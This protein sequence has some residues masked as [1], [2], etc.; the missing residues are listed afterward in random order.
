MAYGSLFKLYTNEGEEIVRSTKENLRK[1]MF[2]YIKEKRTKGYSLS[3]VIF[4]WS[5][6]SNIRTI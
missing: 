2:K 5:P 1:A 6:I 3:E 4:C